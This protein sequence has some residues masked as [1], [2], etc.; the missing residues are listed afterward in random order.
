MFSSFFFTSSK[1]ELIAAYG[2]PVE[3]HNVITDDGYILGLHRIPAPGKQP[4]LLVHGLM[5]SSS[6][7]VL[8]GPGNALGTT[9]FV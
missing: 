1:P 4:V 7:F 5:D 2:Y 9:I 6:A 3:E 8:S